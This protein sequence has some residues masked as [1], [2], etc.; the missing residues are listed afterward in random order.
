M[1]TEQTEVEIEPATPEYNDLND[2]A[3]YEDG[4]R[5]VVCDRTNP[6]AWISAE[7]TRAL[8]P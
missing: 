2:F 8:D 3:S 4:E 5:L 1:R 6:K 7:T